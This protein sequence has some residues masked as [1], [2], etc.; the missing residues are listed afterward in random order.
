MC[1]TPS[2]SHSAMGDGTGNSLSSRQGDETE[3]NTTLRGQGGD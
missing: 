1:R 3:Q 2:I